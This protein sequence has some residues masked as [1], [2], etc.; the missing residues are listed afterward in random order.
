MFLLTTYLLFHLS[1]THSFIGPN[2]CIG[3]LIFRKLFFS[4]T[5]S[6]ILSISTDVFVSFS[7]KLSRSD[8]FTFM[9]WHQIAWSET[10]ISVYSSYRSVMLTEWSIYIN[11]NHCLNVYSSI[12]TWTHVV[13]GS[14]FTL[15]FI[16]GNQVSRSTGSSVSPSTAYNM[17]V[18]NR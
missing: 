4:R 11:M 18:T 3:E 5:Y 10:N 14:S 9:S 12:Y 6:F 8:I 15:P 2:K 16:A 1:W 17:V 7:P 13:V